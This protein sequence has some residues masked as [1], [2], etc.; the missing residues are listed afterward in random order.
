M[1]NSQ[2]NATPSQPSSSAGLYPP[3]GLISGISKPF[4]RLDNGTWLHGRPEKDVFA[5]LID[6][7]RLSVEDLY[8]LEYINEEDSVYVGAPSGLIGFH[9]FLKEV[10]AKPG[11]LPPWWTSAK[12]KNCEDLGMDA[13][14][15]NDLR[16]A[17][18]KADII[19]HYGHYKFPMQLRMFGED[20]YGW[21]PGGDSSGGEM[22]R[23]L[24]AIED[25]KR[26]YGTTF[27]LSSQSTIIHGA[28][29]SKCD[30]MQRSNERT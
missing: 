7:Y 19:K 28:R 12:V 23:M 2:T 15:W 16:C 10:A 8:N 22:R 1:C 9:R 14:Q 13:S 27:D 6:V 4:T 26:M 20:V 11:L 5:L 17:V 24:M 18:E 25:G 30:I 3:K 29:S 21:V